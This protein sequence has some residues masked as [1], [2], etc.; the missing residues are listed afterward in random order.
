MNKLLVC[1][2][3]ILVVVFGISSMSH[4]GVSVPSILSGDLDWLC[5]EADGVE[6]DDS[7]SLADQ[8]T[9][10]ESVTVRRPEFFC[11]PVSKNGST[12]L[13]SNLL[14]FTCYRVEVDAPKRDIISINQFSV[15]LEDRLFLRTKDAKLLCVGSIKEG[16]D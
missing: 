14:H 13:F 9:E 4:A 1:G 8:F 6:V 2:V 7:V 12:P 10:T 16:V 11:N 5:Y 15:E 3:I